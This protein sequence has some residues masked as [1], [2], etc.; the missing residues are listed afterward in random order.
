M[1]HA[2][3]IYEARV[4]YVT[5]AIAEVNAVCNAV[6]GELKVGQVVAKDAD[7]TEIVFGDEQKASL[8]VIAELSGTAAQQA[9]EHYLSVLE[10]AKS[11]EN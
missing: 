2:A 5:K 4:N 1:S 11:D 9:F 6:E 10:A 7:G 8:K 3:T